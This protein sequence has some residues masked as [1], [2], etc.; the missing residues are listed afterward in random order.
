MLYLHGCSRWT[1]LALLGLIL[2]VAGLAGCGG[3]KKKAVVFGNITYKGEALGNGKVVF[4]GKDG[5]GGSSTI[6][7]DGRYR[8][9]D[10]PVGPVKITVETVPP[11]SSKV[12]LPDAPAMPSMTGGPSNPDSSGKYVPIPAQYRSPDQTPLTYEV[13]PGEQQ[14]DITLE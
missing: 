2:C 12:N 8:M 13:K 5:K 4:I 6:G 10:V 9:A 1:R 3:M 11:S 14:K 7:P